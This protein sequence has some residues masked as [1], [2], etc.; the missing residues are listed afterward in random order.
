MGLL[1]PCKH[2]HGEC[3]T[4]QY[5]VSKVHELICRGG[6][7]YDVE[8]MIWKAR[9][10]EIAHDSAEN[11]LARKAQPRST[12]WYLSRVARLGQQLKALLS[13]RGKEQNR[14]VSHMAPADEGHPVSQSNP[15]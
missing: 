12:R 1:L 10:K 9:I 4:A 15:G 3:P 5:L 6:I 14:E 2:V 7:M 13:V 8:Y 11:R